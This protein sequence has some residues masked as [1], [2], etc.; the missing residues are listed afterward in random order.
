MWQHSHIQSCVWPYLEC[1]LYITA[2]WVMTRI[3]WT[4]SHT[5]SLICTPLPWVLTVYCCVVSHNTHRI[6]NATHRNVVC[7]IE[8][9]GMWHTWVMSH[10]NESCHTW[11]SHVT[12]EWVMS[13]MNE[14]CHTWMSHV[15]HESCHTW[16]SD[17]THMREGYP[18]YERVLSHIWM[19]HVTYMHEPCH[20]RESVMSHIRTSPVTYMNESLIWAHRF[21]AT[22]CSTLQHTAT[23]CNTT[24]AELATL[25]LEKKETVKYNQ[26]THAATR[27]ITL[28]HTTTHCN[29]L[30][31]ELAMLRE[32]MTIIESSQFTHATTRRNTLQH[33][34]TCCNTLQDTA[35]HRKRSW[36]RWY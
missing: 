27:C 7:R 34:A 8:E 13:H 32:T 15:T 30:E 3:E 9:A 18:E 28:H 22:H 21:F 23:H 12:H 16:M 31:A 25:K 6:G 4:M 33:A 29:I 24:E 11:M 20:T 2:W 5:D 36:R 1:W 14:S 10:M 35:T 19:N 17:D 26:F